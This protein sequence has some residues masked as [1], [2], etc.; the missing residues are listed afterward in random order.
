MSAAAWTLGGIVVAGIAAW[1]AARMTAKA[2]LQQSLN[3]TFRI[4]IAS[5]ERRIGE[6]EAEVS[7]LRGELRQATQIIE[8]AARLSGKGD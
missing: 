2:P 1:F 3:D 4:L 8:S 5:Q 6:L 7:R